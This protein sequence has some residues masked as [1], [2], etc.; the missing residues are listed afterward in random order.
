ML[1]PLSLSESNDYSQA[2]FLEAAL[3]VLQGVC[4][5]RWF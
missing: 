2:R 5:L 1:S 4:A 3:Q